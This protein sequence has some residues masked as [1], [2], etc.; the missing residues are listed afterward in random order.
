[1]QIRAV[2][3]PV[4]DDGFR[5]CRSKYLRRTDRNRNILREIKSRWH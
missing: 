5:K 1:V 4:A 2:S 3:K